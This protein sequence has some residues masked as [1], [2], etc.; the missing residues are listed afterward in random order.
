M[1]RNIWANEQNFLKNVLEFVNFLENCEKRSGKFYEIL[2]FSKN[3]GE[4]LVNLGINI[5][6]Y[7]KKNNF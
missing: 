2:A 4:I 6:S 3:C 7:L 5:R 1:F